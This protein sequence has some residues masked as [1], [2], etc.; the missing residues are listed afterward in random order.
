VGIPFVWITNPL[1]A[2]P[3]FGMNFLVGCRLLD[4][5]C[6]T[7]RFAESFAAVFKQNLGLSDRLQASW[8][9][10]GELF[11]PLC[12]GSLVVAA[13]LGVVSYLVTYKLAASYQ[14]RKCFWAK[15]GLI[16]RNAGYRSLD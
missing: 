12:V 14:N 7:S 13:A 8:Q 5:D 16:T 4:V 6:S 3:L 10:T 11:L 1:T 2:V 15:P 9:I